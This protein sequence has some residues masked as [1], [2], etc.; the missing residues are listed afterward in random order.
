LEA[1]SKSVARAVGS[2]MGR[3]LVRGL[4]GTLLKR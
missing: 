4:F 3:Q 2:Q 1:M